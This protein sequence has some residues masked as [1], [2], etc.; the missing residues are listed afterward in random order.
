MAKTRTE[1]FEHIKGILNDTFEVPLENI[2][3][4][5]TLYEKLD[6]DSI[7][8]IDIFTQLRELTGRRPDPA[9]AREVRTIADLV[10]FVEREIA[11]GPQT[12]APDA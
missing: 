7:D 5:A 2:T 12:E 9:E 11:K 3:E 8:A 1:I 6:L 10:A 4:D